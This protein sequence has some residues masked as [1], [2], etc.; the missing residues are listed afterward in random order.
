MNHRAGALSRLAHPETLDLQRKL[1][2]DAPWDF[3]AQVLYAQDLT[4]AG[5]F[6]DA[7]A[8]LQKQ[9]D[10][11]PG[12]GSGDSLSDSPTAGPNVA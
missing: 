6:D 12:D 5:E 7:L 10:D 3:S 9:L 4:A 2:T 1:A 8:W 11:Y